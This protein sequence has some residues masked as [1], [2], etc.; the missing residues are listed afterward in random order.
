VEVRGDDHEEDHGV[1]E[2]GVGDNLHEVVAA[3]A[4]AAVVVVEDHGVEVE[5]GMIRCS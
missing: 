2:V 1:E 4:A 3:A 5:E